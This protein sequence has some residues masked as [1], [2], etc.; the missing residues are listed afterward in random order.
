MFVLTFVFGLGIFVLFYFCATLG[1]VM[2]RKIDI[3]V[4]GVFFVFFLRHT[5]QGDGKA[6]QAGTQTPLQETGHR[7]RAEDWGPKVSC[8]HLQ[9]NACKSGMRGPHSHQH[10]QWNNCTF[11][12]GFSSPDYGFY[13]K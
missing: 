13:Y 5:G 12:N 6:G 1:R 8:E 7:L 10:P 3:C 9:Y 4:C 11:A 2:G